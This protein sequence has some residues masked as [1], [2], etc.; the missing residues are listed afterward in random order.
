M[1]DERPDESTTDARRTGST[2][3]AGDAKGVGCTR[4]ALAR[5]LSEAVGPDTREEDRARAE[6]EELQRCFE[7]G[8]LNSQLP[9]GLPHFVGSEHE[10]WSDGKTVTKATLP[11]SFGRC[12]GQRRFATAS[13]Y[14]ERIRLA[15]SC[16]ELKWQVI[17]LVKEMGCIRMVTIQP[18]FAGEAPNR[19]EIEGWFHQNR[20]EHR[21]HKLGDHWFRE[22]DSVLV[23]DAEPGNLVK[24]P[25]GI[26]PIDVILQTVS[27]DET[28][29]FG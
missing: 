8:W 11:G 6:E 21:C 28:A 16:F 9:S 12:W 7:E 23:Y 25:F 24:T 19:S 4:G 18:L 26:A 15:E 20:F 5:R 27:S 13:E 14:L 17:G 29:E 1:T 22:E 2:I 10:V 3:G